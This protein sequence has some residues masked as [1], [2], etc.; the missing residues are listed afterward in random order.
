MTALPRLRMR[1]A[2][3]HTALAFTCC[4]V[5][6]AVVALGMFQGSNTSS[7]LSDV[8][9]YAGVALALLA[10]V[11]IAVGWL[12]AGR[13]LRPLDAITR[14]ARSLSA[15]DLE[16]RL[17]V[18]PGYREFTELAGTL[19][20]LLRRLHE[21][22][23]A[24]RQFVANASHELR[25]PLTV[26]RTLLQLALDDPSP[27]ALRSACE[28]LL[29]LNRQQEQLIDALLTLATG[30]DGIDR[31]EAFDLAA[32]TA[33]I[34]EEHQPDADARHVDI[35]TTLAPT[36]VT[37]DVPLTASLIT[38]LLVNA[39]R[40]NLPGGTVHVT[41]ADGRLTITNT[42]RQIPSD[43]LRTLTEPF[44]RAQSD[45]HGLGLAIATAVARA[46]SADLTI[47]PDPNGGLRVSYQAG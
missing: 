19:D 5:V 22:F 2:V 35:R 14:S 47:Q 43:E 26:Q 4:V 46:H 28:E 11:S 34:V 7:N 3:L 1:L 44:Q 39:I 37:G 33:R 45:G 12:I 42:G 21:S 32:L 30:Y 16:T 40:H 18:P 9:R 24:Q 8:L 20:D 41:T 29:D 38:N 10:V 36:A 15:Q 31:W 17:T 25:T 27:D 6:V 13:A 23:T